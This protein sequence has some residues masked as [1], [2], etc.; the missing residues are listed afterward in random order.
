[1]RMFPYYVVGLAVASYKSMCVSRVKV[2]KS[3]K[4]R[5]IKPEY[6]KAETLLGGGAFWRHLTNYE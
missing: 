5:T 2:V 4:P 3:L 1:M 6:L